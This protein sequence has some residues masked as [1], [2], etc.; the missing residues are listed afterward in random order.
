[1]VFSKTIRNGF[2]IPSKKELS[3]GNDYI[4]IPA[5]KIMKFPMLQHIGTPAKP[6]VEVGDYVK[7]GE[8][9]GSKVGAVSANVHS[10]VS[11]K[12][13]KIE[14]SNATRGNKVLCVYI[15]NDEKY[16]H[17]YEKID[18]NYIDLS[19]KEIVKL[20]E[21]AGITGLGGASFPTHVK[22]SPPEQIE[23]VILNGAECEPY[24]TADDTMMRNFA[25]DIVTGLKIE[26]HALNAKNGYI[27]IE[28]DK[29]ESI[30]A[31]KSASKNDENIKVVVAETKYPQ[32]DEKQVIDV[33][34]GREIPFGNNTYQSGVIVSNVTTAYAIKQAVCHNKPLYERLVTF[35]GEAMNKKMNALIQ[36]GT[37]TSDC[38]KYIGGID[39]DIIDRVLLG[40]PMMGYA[41]EDL[42]IPIEKST[43]GVLALSKEE[44]EKP[45]RDPCIKCAA[46]VEV[47]P[48]GLQ[49][50]NLEVLVSNGRIEEAKANN[51]MSCIECGLCSYICPSHIPLVETFKE[52]KRIIRD[53]KLKK[54]EK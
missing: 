20:V 45:D 53:F 18:R 27:L 32:G 15:E 44:T 38:V 29:P 8:K 34:L 41:Q 22:L 19:P 13:I 37:Q 5:S 14:Y 35:S 46:C 50:F 21:E 23:H 42:S 52:G 17:G 39:D 6:A 48:I 4:K 51:I 2:H 16:E 24:L 9:I 36:L 12:V 30:K 3:R 7:V 47:C 54:G 43:N 25:E 10:S 26:L 28:D 40:G 1:M 49:P 11:G 33:V 31:I